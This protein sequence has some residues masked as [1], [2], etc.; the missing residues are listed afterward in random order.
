MRIVAAAE[1]V[2]PSV[3][4]IDVRKG[5]DRRGNRES[6]GSGSGFIITPDSFSHE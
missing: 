2:S 3:V 4:K 5:G 6:G 1:L